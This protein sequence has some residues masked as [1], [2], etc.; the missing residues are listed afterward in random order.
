MRIV[1][2]RRLKLL[3][4]ALTLVACSG[5]APAPPSAPVDRDLVSAWRLARFAFERGQYDQAADLYERVLERAY[6]RDDL[7]AIGDVGYELAVVD[8]R[9]GRPEDA[10]A[11][12]RRTREELAR[13]G[14]R[15]FAELHLVEGI[16]LYDA[17]D[18]DGAE[19]GADAALDL[20]GPDDP[21]LARAL[22]LKGVIAADRGRPNE[23]AHLL[24]ALGNAQTG[25][26]RA[27][28]LELEG[29]LDLLEDRP[30]AALPAFREGAALRREL[31][32]YRGMAR[33]LAF[34]AEAAEESGRAAE[35]A[36]LYFR[37]GRS[38]GIEGRTAAA[39]LWL[40]TAIGL[41]EEAGREEIR[42]EATALLERLA[43]QG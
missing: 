4:L 18:L 12:A 31:E 40:E 42:D 37:A 21:V 28:R 5:D 13:R 34:A 29:R 30:E 22:Y 43:E 7:R 15:P 25:A 19:A 23:L 9:R 14:A 36:D 2:R 26:L 6:A 17:G 16:A 10:A 8:L 24:L 41:A 27:D 38:A 35:A 11:R 39:R 32:D 1:L 3:G 33:A 20:A